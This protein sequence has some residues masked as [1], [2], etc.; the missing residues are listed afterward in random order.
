M[1]IF[2][3]HLFQT[4]KTS[5]DFIIETFF[6]CYGAFK[7]N[8]YF[9]KNHRRQSLIVWVLTE[10]ME[11]ARHHITYNWKIV[12]STVQTSRKYFPSNY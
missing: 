4:A 9:F 1:L 5:K 2:W 11:Q 8:S 10:N 3:N 6:A 7:F 12:L